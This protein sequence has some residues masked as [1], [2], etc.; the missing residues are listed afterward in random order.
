MLVLISVGCASA[1]LVDRYREESAQW[2]G[3]IT[4]AEAAVT[5]PAEGQP[6]LLF[7]GSSSIRLWETIETDMA[8]FQVTRLGFGGAKLSD[9]AVYADRLTHPYTFE[10]L[11]LFVGN[12]IWGNADDKS[13]EEIAALFEYIVERTRV[14]HPTVP[15]YWIEIT[16]SPSRWHLFGQVDEAQRA[17]EAATE[18]L[19]NVHFIPTKDVF[20]AGNGEPDPAYFIEDRLHLSEAGYAAWA[21]RIRQ[22]VTP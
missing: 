19:P 4:A 18:R 17:I 6:H 11:M 5:P 3:D 12:D 15:I 14:Q 21:E 7:V 1:D 16:H 9:V 20:L 8:P 10:A 2:E 22:H 13:A